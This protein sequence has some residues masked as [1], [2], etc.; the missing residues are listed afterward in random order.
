MKRKG[1]RIL[2]FLMAVV[3]LLP[4]LSPL[5]VLAKE[6]EIPVPESVMIEPVGGVSE[7]GLI[8]DGYE[9]EMPLK[10]SQYF[11]VM[12]VESLPAEYRSPYATS[13]KDQNPYG[14]CWTFSSAALMEINAWKKGLAT[15]ADYS[16]YHIGYT[17]YNREGVDDPLG[18]TLG[19]YMEAP[20]LWYESG[21]N[22]LYTS[23][24]L[25]S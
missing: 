25:S 16:E 18:N 1:R 22:L 5:E 11:S 2:M 7:Y 9:P 15:E 24:S 14:T 23:L 4:Y 19:D 8:D 20:E 12:G 10:N 21:G 17:V 3:L 6:K 13:I